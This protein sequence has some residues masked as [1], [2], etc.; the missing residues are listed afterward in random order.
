[1]NHNLQDHFSYYIKKVYKE[2]IPIEQGI[3]LQRA[4][5]AGAATMVD[6]LNKCAEADQDNFDIIID[7]ILEELENYSSGIGKKL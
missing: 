2:T 6:I 3:E 1:M 4:F 5:F 7:D